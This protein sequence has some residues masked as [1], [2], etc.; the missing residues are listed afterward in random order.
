MQL[1]EKMNYRMAS[2][3]TILLGRESVSRVDGAMIELI[4]NA[5]DA[6]ASICYICF[7][8][9]SNSIYIIDNGTGMT[10]DVIENHWMMIGTDNKRVEFYSSKRRIKS[11]EKGIGRFALDRLGSQCTMFTKSSSERLIRWYTDWT[12]FEVPG[13]TLDEVEAEFEY[14]DSDINDHIPHSIILSIKNIQKT[15]NIQYEFSTGTMLKIS[16]LR[17]K[18]TENQISKTIAALGF[19]VPPGEQTTFSIMIQN[20][21]NEQGYELVSDVS[22][23]YDYRIEAR[24]DGAC[25]VV[26]VERNELDL[27]VMPKDIFFHPRFVHVPFRYDDLKKGSYTVTYTIPELMKNNDPSF[28]D[29]VAEL[30][31]FDFLYSFMKSSSRD[32]GRGINYYKSISRNRKRWLEEYSGIK[33]YRDNFVVRPYG[34]KTSNAYDWLHLDARKAINPVAVSDKSEQWHVSNSQGQGTIFISRVKNNVILDK[35]SREGI[36]EN[37][38]FLVFCGVIRELIS[39]FERDRAYIARTIRLY[40][41]EKEERER[42]KKEAKDIA[43]VL[44]KNKIK[45]DRKQ[46]ND[47]ETTI[48]SGKET[49]ALKLAQAVQYFD[50]EVEDLISEIRLLRALATNGLITT[51]MIHDLK[52]L[53]AMLVSRVETLQMAV[54]EK[55]ENLIKRHLNDL[56]LNDKFLKSWITVITTQTNQGKRKRLRKNLSEVVKNCVTLLT[57]ILER[58]KVNVIMSIEENT[59]DLQIFETDFDS[60]IYNL[61]INS[62]ESFEHANCFDRKIMIKTE[63]TDSEFFIRYEDNGAGL[64]EVFLAEPYKIFEYGT[65]SKFDKN[66][67]QLGTGLGMYIFAS[68]VK[69]YKGDY[70]FTKIQNGFGIDI[71]IP[72]G[73]VA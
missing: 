51:S 45:D 7:D 35:S 18:W 20:S 68:S 56:S 2:R 31:E 57:P 17:D 69:E 13:K 60:I 43:E 30:G 39:V 40:T 58:K 62:I 24:F 53:N 72:R 16:G 23:D 29:T 48:T 19:L 21:I 42:A 36:I 22:V 34:D 27:A 70:K 5:Y 66:G 4:K 47:K 50:E 46:S 15:R 59:F 64:S 26:K 28:I 67:N 44:I 49:D 32:D 73:G 11:G 25:F 6:D 71:T 3:A 65:T 55:N 10:K 61:I 41:E 37:E 1:V 33:I 52:S 38:H 8:E 63:S 54:E 14:L 9:E 12:S